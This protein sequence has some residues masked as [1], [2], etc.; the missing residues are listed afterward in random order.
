MPNIIRTIIPSLRYLTLKFV[1]KNASNKLTI[2]KPTQT[3]KY[4]FDSSYPIF[5]YS[6]FA[7]HRIIYYL[8]FYVKQIVR[9][10]IKKSITLESSESFKIYI[11]FSTHRNSFHFLIKYI[12]TKF[13]RI[14]DCSLNIIFRNSK[15]CAT[16]RLIYKHIATL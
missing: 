16:F 1:N 4:D 6:S 5:P 13:H 3:F 12:F 2:P 7:Y 9:S 11:L 8:S 14:S 15:L 10:S